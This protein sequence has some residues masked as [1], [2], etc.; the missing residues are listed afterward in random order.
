MGQN[1]C[2]CLCYNLLKLMWFLLLLYVQSQ[3]VVFWQKDLCMLHKSF[4]VNIEK[5]NITVTASINL[6]N[7][8]CGT[9]VSAVVNPRNSKH[10]EKNM[11]FEA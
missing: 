10:S 2:K 3:R 5:T 8:L 4:E 9:L 7:L 11:M 1:I 6:R